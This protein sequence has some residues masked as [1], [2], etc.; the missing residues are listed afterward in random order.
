MEGQV[1]TVIDKVTGKEYRAQFEGDTL[2][3]NEMLVPELRTDDMGQMDNP[4]FD[5]ETRTFYDKLI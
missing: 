1:F 3:E 2:A 5:F 4:Y